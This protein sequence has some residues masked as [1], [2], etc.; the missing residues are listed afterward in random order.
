M[1]LVDTEFVP[2]I[3]QIASQIPKQDLLKLM[4]LEWLSNYEQFHQNSQLVQTSES[5]Y[6]KRPDGTV[7]MTFKPPAE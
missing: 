6:E 1:I 4:P 7:R 2:T 3:I 5:S